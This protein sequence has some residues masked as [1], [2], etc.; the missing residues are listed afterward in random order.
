MSVPRWVLDAARRQPWLRERAGRV[1]DAVV[2]ASSVSPP[3]LEPGAWAKHRGRATDHTPVVVLDCTGL[4]HEP[5]QALVDRLPQVSQAAGGARF[6]LVVDGAQ[7]AVGRRAGVVVEHVIDEQAWARRHD[8]AGWPTYRAQRFAQLVRT[9]RPQ[10]V[11][12]LPTGDATQLQ[13][14]IVR[15]GARPVWRRALSRA[16][17]VIDPPPRGSA[18]PPRRG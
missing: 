10:Q 2:A 17:R 14:E 18:A 8:P 16:E 11:C 15:R 7:L 6:V 1:V 5:L 12:V 9:Y 3:G 13:R 4:G